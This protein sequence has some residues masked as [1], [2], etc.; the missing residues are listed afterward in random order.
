MLTRRPTLF[1]LYAHCKQSTNATVVGRRAC[2]KTSAPT[3][4]T[5]IG[6]PIVLLYLC[7]YTYV[8]RQAISMCAYLLIKK[9]RRPAQRKCQRLHGGTCDSGSKMHFE[10]FSRTTWPESARF[11][12]LCSSFTCSLFST[13]EYCCCENR[14]LCNSTP[15]RSCIYMPCRIG[16]MNF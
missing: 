4:E 14:L 15:T 5:M 7:I 1:F 10:K 6:W 9:K 3:T 16:R 13:R 11:R 12:L 8:Q 2:G